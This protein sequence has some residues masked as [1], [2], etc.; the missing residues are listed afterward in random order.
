MF[1]RP[2]IRARPALGWG[3]LLLPPGTAIATWVFLLFAFPLG[4]LLIPVMLGACVLMAWNVSNSVAEWR[5]TV[6]QEEALETYGDGPQTDFVIRMRRALFA[7]ELIAIAW[8][9]PWFLG[10]LALF[11]LFGV[12]VAAWE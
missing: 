8:T 6:R 1:D 3:L 7:M 5:F 11:H 10:V 12:K 4:C 2:Y 9:L